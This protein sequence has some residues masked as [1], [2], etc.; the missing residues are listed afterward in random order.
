MPPGPSPTRAAVHVPS[1]R[2]VDRHARCGAALC[3]ARREAE[4]AWDATAATAGCGELRR[5][6][7]QLRGCCEQTDAGCGCGSARLVV[8]RSRRASKCAA[9]VVVVAMHVVMSK[10][11]CHS[12]RAGVVSR[13]SVSNFGHATT[14]CAST[15]FRHGDAMQ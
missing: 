15:A 12:R 13:S 7:R 1:W 4:L 10:P 8:G 6:C 3:A 5:D 9:R 2:A 11:G 14:A